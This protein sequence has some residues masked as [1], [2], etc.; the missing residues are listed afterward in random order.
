MPFE[1]SHAEPFTVDNGAVG[2]VVSH[3]FTGMP[4][5]MRG[6]AEH[7]AD[8]GLSVR[9]PLLPGHGT[10][11]RDANKVTWQEW[12]GTIEA[13]YDDL[14]GRC[15]HVFVA[16][17]SMGGTLA[18]RLAQ[19]RPDVAGVMLVNPSVFTLRKDAKL[20]PLLHRF[21]PAFPPI[22]SDIKK[23]GV[24]E[25]AYDRLPV[26][27]AHQLSLMW[28]QV[29]ADLPKITQPL[30]VFTSREDHVV[31]PENSETVLATVSSTQKRQVW[32][33]DSHHVA[34]MD[35]D[36]PTIFEESVRFVQAHAPSRSG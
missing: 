18:L 15:E 5:S 27:A 24:Q 9:L 34:T 11:W 29:R 1:P 17:L 7:L 30:L 35:N 36:A 23:P 16:G 14:R 6:W 8:A 3:G 28:K 33:E 31:E 12:V 13:A 20:L 19:V 4:A 2:V 10:H 25:P 22:A 32:L 21:V 26:K